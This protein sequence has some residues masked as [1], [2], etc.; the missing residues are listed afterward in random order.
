MLV[1][2]TRHLIDRTLC[3]CSIHVEYTVYNISRS[4]TSRTIRALVLLAQHTAEQH[5]VI[6]V[7]TDTIEKIR[8][9]VIDRYAHLRLSPVIDMRRIRSVRSQLASFEGEAENTPKNL[10]YAVDTQYR[11]L[12]STTIA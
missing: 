12:N 1:R 3:F 10:D 9:Y 5:I 6:R 2:S 8:L 7:S 11:L 4:A